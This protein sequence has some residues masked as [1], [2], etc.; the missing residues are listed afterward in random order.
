MRR[1][2]LY[3]PPLAGKTT[4]LKQFAASKGLSLTRFNPLQ[5]AS[6]QTV[7]EGL[8][9]P[10]EGAEIEDYGLFVAD[11]DGDAIVVTIGGSFWNRNSW[12]ALLPSAS[13]IALVLDP[14]RAR[15]NANLE[16]VRT[17]SLDPPA[18]GAIVWTKQDIVSQ[19]DSE[20]IDA[21]DKELG[22]S[23]ARDWPR[24]SIRSDRPNTQIAA[25]NHIISV[26]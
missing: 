14:Q 8:P 13:A 25:V 20:V 12:P 26:M 19:V 6:P 24:M 17:I 22:G 18:H 15:L 3:G 2:L 1:V 16:F 21:I 23:R 5:R 4:I 11:R 10:G 7:A 9:V